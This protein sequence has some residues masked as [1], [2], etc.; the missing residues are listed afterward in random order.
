[1]RSSLA[2]VRFLGVVSL[3]VTCAGAILSTRGGQS[4][5]PT[6]LQIVGGL[7]MLVCAGLIKRH[8]DR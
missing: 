2:A 7:G 3:G 1:M 6:T 4:V 5:L 8:A